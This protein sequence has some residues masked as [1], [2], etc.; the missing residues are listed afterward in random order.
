MNEFERALKF[1]L[2]I[3]GGY[4]NDKYDPGGETKFG[5]SK[6][7]LSPETRILTKSLNWIALNNIE[8]GDDIIAFDEFPEIHGKSHVRRLRFAKVLEKSKLILPCYMLMTTKG[9]IICSAEHLWL[10]QH[11]EHKCFDWVKTKDLLS[12]REGDKFTWNKTRNYLQY[13]TN[14]WEI[15][16]SYNAGYIAGFLD[17]EGSISSS[18]ITFYQND[19]KALHKILKVLK[20]EKIEATLQRD[21]INK[22]YYLKTKSAFGWLRVLGQYQPVRLIEKAIQ[23]LEGRSVSSPLSD[24]V[25]IKDLIFLGNKEVI[26]LKTT[27]NTLIAEGFL[28]HNSYPNLDIKNLTVAQAKEIYKRDYWDK[29]CC[30][31]YMFPWNV[32]M[33]D[34]AVHH[35][36]GRAKIF[37]KKSKTWQEMLLIRMEYMTEC[38]N[39]KIYMLG[40]ARRIAKLYDF[41]ESELKK[42]DSLPQ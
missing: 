38:R 7:C 23:Q 20:E 28:T 29:A 30:D 19:N 16:T 14:P 11:G 26:G 34:S 3:E 27:T 12:K 5:I 31:D 8:V 41:I 10:R 18:N 4:V 39:S 22:S 2:T 9:N 24:L 25:E 21:T 37:W 13:F 40:W 42:Y 35:G 36:V 33:F 1:T 17:G 15:D 32:I 6:K